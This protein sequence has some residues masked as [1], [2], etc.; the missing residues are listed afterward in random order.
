VSETKRARLKY[1]A[2]EART[3]SQLAHDYLL[4][5]LTY[6]GDYSFAVALI[7]ISSL[8]RY[9]GFPSAC[10]IFS[11]IPEDATCV[12][13]MS[14]STLAVCCFLQFLNDA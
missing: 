2:A 8:G 7:T 9:E 11:T 5:V 13:H 14:L 3:Y 4:S 12:M 6:C 10:S 1:R